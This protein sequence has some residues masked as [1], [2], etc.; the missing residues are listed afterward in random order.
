MAYSGELT[1]PVTR[2]AGL[3]YLYYFTCIILMKYDPAAV[4]KEQGE[5]SSR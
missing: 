2:N 1:G 4:G 3:F 5:E